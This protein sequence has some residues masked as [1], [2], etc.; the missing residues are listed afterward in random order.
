MTAPEE[1][2][3]SLRVKAADI[4]NVIWGTGYRSDFSMSIS[5][6]ILGIIF[7]SHSLLCAAIGCSGAMPLWQLSVRSSWAKDSMNCV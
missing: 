2:L 1:T 7:H 6:R 4:T 3:P 5:T